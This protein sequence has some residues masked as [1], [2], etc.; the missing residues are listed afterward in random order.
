M[1]QGNEFKGSF[2]YILKIPKSE[3]SSLE[4][5]R[6]RNKFSPYP[7]DKIFPIDGLIF[8]Y[9]KIKPGMFNYHR[10]EQMTLNKKTANLSRI[11]RVL[12]WFSK[13]K[14]IEED[15][16]CKKI[17]SN[18][19]KL[20]DSDISIIE[21]KD[22]IQKQK[23]KVYDIS[24]EETESFFGNDFPVLLHNSG[25]KGFHIIVP[26]KAFPEEIYG[27]KTKNIFPEWPRIICEY[28]SEII[29]PRLIERLLQDD[30]LKQIAKKTGKQE[31]DL[32]VKECKRCNR[33]AIKKFLITWYCEY[34][35]KEFTNLEG[36]YNNR[37]KSKCPDCRKELFEKTKQEIYI[38]EYC[39]VNSQRN[40]ELFEE[41]ERFATEKLIDADLV[42]VAPR[43]LFRAP[44]SL[45][46]KTSLASV[47]ID[48]DKIKDFQ[49]KDAKPFSITIK[50]YYPNAKENEA[51]NLLLQA[52]DWKEQKEK[53]ENIIKETKPMQNLKKSENFKK[54]SIPNPDES[55]FP[56]CIKLI[57]KGVKDDGRKRALFVLINFFKSL[58]V[59]DE[60]IEKRVDEWNKKNY[61]PLKKGYIQSQLIWH[62]R[63]ITRLPPNCDK[64][65]YKEL[66]VCKPDELCRQIK[67]PVN[68][69][70]KR[71]FWKK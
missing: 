21:V 55:I 65:N 17:I 36:T 68:Y 7:R 46:E 24:V 18:Y 19:E 45:H 63:N 60:E 13:Y 2:V 28:L 59:S 53:T 15:G 5:N 33:P 34:C 67:N 4:F 62:K 50:N 42:L 16:E 23:D 44:Y 14:T 29:Q 25:S 51:K 11:R 3:L 35:K 27:Q 47:V 54:L 58:G 66:N 37:K 56:P 52:L 40:P 32:I 38:C 70:F 61:S 26:W 22:I 6:S 69:S 43:H 10:R 20:F 41:K 30:S 1:P 8:V 71:Y 49:I 48:K 9:K 64:P 39:N 31:Q 57:L 12:D